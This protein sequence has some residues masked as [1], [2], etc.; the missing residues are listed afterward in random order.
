MIKYAY[1]LTKAFLYFKMIKFSKTGFSLKDNKTF[2]HRTIKLSGLD[3]YLLLC[4]LFTTKEHK[5]IPKGSQSI[6]SGS[7]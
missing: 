7:P 3:I 4:Y 6:F 1:N 5:V 2:V